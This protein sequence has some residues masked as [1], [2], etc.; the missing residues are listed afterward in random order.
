[1]WWLIGSAPDFWGAAF[2]CPWAFLAHL[3]K[4]KD[5]E[6]VIVQKQYFFQEYC[7]VMF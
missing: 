1:M 4:N 5:F 7:E 2:L 3:P 6:G